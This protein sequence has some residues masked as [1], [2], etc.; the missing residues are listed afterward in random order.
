ME[1]KAIIFDFDN[2]LVDRQKAAYS[3]FKDF[4]KGYFP[5][6]NPSTVEYEG[7]VQQLVTWDEFGALD[8]R[9][10]FQQFVKWFKLDPSLIEEM[11]VTWYDRFNTYTVAYPD[12]KE[13]LIALSEKYRIGMITNGGSAQRAKLEV[14][15]L[16][17]FFEC[18]IVSRE[19]DTNKPDQVL[20]DMACHQ[21]EVKPEECLFV[22]DTFDTDIV[23]AVQA[24]MQAVWIVSDPLRQS[25]Y[26]VARIQTISELLDLLQEGE[27]A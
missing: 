27:I 21:L 25:D 14:S 8:R 9:S 20:F 7:I 5:H 13:V 22:G 11:L 6:L 26:P 18:V 19:H 10:V 15:G 1:I 16:G 23:G 24:G 4:V 2:T 17:D 12:A 3:Y